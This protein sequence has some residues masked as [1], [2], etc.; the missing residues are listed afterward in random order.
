MTAPTTH[1]WPF[2]RQTDEQV[3]YS[4]QRRINRQLPALRDRLFRLSPLE[5]MAILGQLTSEAFMRMPPDERVTTCRSWTDA[6][7]QGVRDS[8]G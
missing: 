2:G 4:V 5:A 7:T 6:I 8:L 3:A 1:P